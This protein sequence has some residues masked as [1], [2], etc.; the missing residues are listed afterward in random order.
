VEIEMADR[1]QFSL[2]ADTMDELIAMMDKKIAGIKAWVVR[3]GRDRRDSEGV[4][5][6][7][8]SEPGPGQGVA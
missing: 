7:T 1:T 2:E 5:A 6:D 3:D 4:A 8:G